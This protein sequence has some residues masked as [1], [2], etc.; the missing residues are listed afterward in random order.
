MFDFPP[1]PHDLP[2]PTKNLSRHEGNTKQTG[3]RRPT[4]SDESSTTATTTSPPAPPRREESYEE[5]CVICL[6]P[7]S[8]TSSWGRCTPCQHSFHKK[9]WWQW[10]YSHN[11]RVTNARR[12]GDAPPVGHPLADKGPKCCLCNVVNERFVDVHGKPI[13]NPQPFV[14]SDEDNNNNEGGGSSSSFGI[15]SMSFNPDNFTLENIQRVMMENLPDEL[16]NGN[17]DFVRQLSQQMM[18]QGGSNGG[19]GGS[20][21]GTFQF[22]PVGQGGS[23]AMGGVGEMFQRIFGGGSNNNDDDASPI[24]PSN[25]NND[26]EVVVG[27]PYNEIREGTP[28]V[29]QNLV[30]SAELNGRHGQVVRFDTSNGRYLVRLRPSSSSSPATTTVAI[31]P[32]NLLQMIQ[33]KIQGLQSQSHLNGCDGTIRS[34]SSERD[35]YVVRVAYRDPEVFQSL[36]P[37]MQLEVS[38]HPP[39]T[40]DISVS[41]SNICIPVGTYVRLEGLEQRAQWNGRYGRIIKWVDNGGDGEGRSGGVGGRYEVRLSRQY[42]VLVK[43]QNVRL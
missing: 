10:E 15:G 37:H 41:S 21:A 31:K 36:P 5:E 28:I 7:L 29:T 13:H 12:R 30:N 24:A 11:Q 20:A 32:E 16:T 3:Q 4:M 18:N 39:E 1:F 34:Y 23:G 40:R 43:P 27:P 38:L 14:A 25:T 9:C 35:R 6:E 42:A 8:E 33:V 26:A 2:S 17:P 19:D 22:P